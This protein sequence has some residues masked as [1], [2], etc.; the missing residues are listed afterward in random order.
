MFIPLIIYSVFFFFF[1]LNVMAKFRRTH[2]TI[3]GLFE[4][5]K[6]FFQSNVL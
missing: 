2:L 4:I 5:F 1:F 6:S 3:F